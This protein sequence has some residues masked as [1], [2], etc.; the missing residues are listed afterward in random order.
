MVHAVPDILARI[1]E[2][3]RA[4]IAR[5]AASR[6]DLELLATARPPSRDFRAALTARPAA[7]IAEIKKASPARAFFS[8]PTIRQI[9]RVSILRA[10]RQP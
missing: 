4:E 6:D 7:I 5:L 3:K 8:R 1:V 2:T 9:S 10:A